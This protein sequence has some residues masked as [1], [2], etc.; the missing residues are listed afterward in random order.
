MR[1]SNSCFTSWENE[2][3]SHPSRL[4]HENAKGKRKTRKKEKKNKLMQ[5]IAL[6]KDDSVKSIRIPNIRDSK[7]RLINAHSPLWNGFSNLQARCLRSPAAQH[8]AV[9]LPQVVRSLGRR[10][11]LMASYFFPPSL[12]G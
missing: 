7:T 8:E 11:S 4:N 10:V 3:I 1:L 12:S 6:K 5:G 9:N 2:G